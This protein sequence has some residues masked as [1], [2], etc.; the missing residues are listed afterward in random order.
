MPE[1]TQ[2][3]SLSGKL[4]SVEERQ[5][6]LNM[7]QNYIAEDPDNRDFSGDEPGDEYDLD[8]ID[9]DVKFIARHVETINYTV[10]DWFFDILLD[11]YGVKDAEEAI[12]NNYK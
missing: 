7:M 5:V 6:L 12:P 9:F 8:T 11:S 3:S 10:D 4:P 1:R 2:H